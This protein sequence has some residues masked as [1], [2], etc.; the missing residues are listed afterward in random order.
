MHNTIYKHLKPKTTTPQTST[1]NTQTNAYLPYIYGLNDRIGKI[2]QKHNIKTI[3]KYRSKLNNF[4]QSV[5]NN[6]PIE[7]QGVSRISR[8]CDSVYMGETKRFV[9]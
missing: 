4:L 9:K 1:I 2:I 8:S 3:F 7:T 6:I 5:K